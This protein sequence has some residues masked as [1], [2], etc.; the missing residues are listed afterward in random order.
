MTYK[1]LTDEYAGQ[2]KK[3]SRAEL[4]IMID[5]MT[6][7]RDQLVEHTIEYNLCRVKYELGKLGEDLSRAVEMTYRFGLKIGAEIK[8]A[9]KR[10]EKPQLVTAE[11]VF[12]EPVPTEYPY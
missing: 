9:L 10:M 3:M 5:Q 1:T 6:L 12:E 11:V 2:L 4:V 8:D 7:E